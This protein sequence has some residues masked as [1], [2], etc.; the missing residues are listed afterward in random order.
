MS[1]P[2]NIATLRWAKQSGQGSVVADAGSIFGAYL[3]G[4]TQPAPAIT[5]EPFNETTGARMLNDM[6]RSEAH[7]AGEPQM[8]ATPLNIGSL[9]YGVLGAKA[10]SGS[11][12][13]YTHTF[14]AAT[15]RP[16]WTFWRMLGN[17]L[18][19]RFVDCKIDK[20]VIAGQT[21]K[22]LTVTATIMGIKPQHR[23]ADETAATVEVT[24][25][26]LHYDGSGA[27]Q[28]EGAAV[29]SIDDWTLTID[30]HG[31]P[32][33]GDSLS[34]IDISE[35]ELTIDLAIRQLYLADS[36]RRRV[37]YNSATPSNNADVAAVIQELTGTPNVDFLFTRSATRT[38]Q[39]QLPRLALMPVDMQPATNQDPL[40]QALTMRALQPSGGATP[41]TAKVK[42]SLSAY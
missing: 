14:T 10:V 35:G 18:W 8:F 19:E 37:A 7:V 3:S 29:A 23:T 34:P 30:N 17:L 12:D 39:L 1:T 26:F 41:L 4:G 27:L 33:G 9:L 11:G 13:P 2:S 22:P 42:N 24:N 25:R 36:L 6:Y 5:D 40:R 38:L 16:W 31:Q 28:V 21:G 15:S 32:I 20:L